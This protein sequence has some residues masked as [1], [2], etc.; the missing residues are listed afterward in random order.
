MAYGFTLTYYITFR[1]QT[2]HASMASGRLNEVRTLAS[3][4]RE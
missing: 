2:M 1:R 4:S 3:L